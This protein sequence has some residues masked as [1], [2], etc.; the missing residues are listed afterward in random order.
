M[1][2]LG[3]MI[4][5]APFQPFLAKML[6]NLQVEQS[7]LWSTLA[8][9]PGNQTALEGFA[10]AF[11]P[12]EKI[13]LYA[14]MASSQNGWKDFKTDSRENLVYKYLKRFLKGFPKCDTF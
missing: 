13:F 3:Y 7:A 1:K 2:G 10:L 4:S 5:R 12:N 14:G 9:V 6:K 8:A 11:I